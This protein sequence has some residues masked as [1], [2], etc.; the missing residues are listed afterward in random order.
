MSD[1]TLTSVTD[2]PQTRTSMDHAGTYDVG[3]VA[4]IVVTFTDS[5]TGAPVDP[6]GQTVSYYQPDGSFVVVAYPATNYVRDAA[7]VY[8]L[9]LPMALAGRYY[10][11]FQATGTGASVAPFSVCSRA[12][13]VP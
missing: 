2:Y 8:R 3:D 1:V 11:Q 9:I 12:P 4:E 5:K 7:G 6:T 13:I 10:G